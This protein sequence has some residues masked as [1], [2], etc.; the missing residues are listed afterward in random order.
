MFVSVVMKI[1]IFNGFEVCNV[2]MQ[3]NKK[4]FEFTSS[5]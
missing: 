5:L 1:L 4:I 2:V 3:R